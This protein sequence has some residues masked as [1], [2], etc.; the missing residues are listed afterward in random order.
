MLQPLLLFLVIGANAIEVEKIQKTFY[1]PYSET[2]DVDFTIDSG[3][4]IGCYR[5]TTDND[6]SIEMIPIYKDYDHQCG[7]ILDLKILPGTANSKGET[8]IKITATDIRSDPESENGKLDYVVVVAPVARVSMESVKTKF[9]ASDAAAPFGLSAYDANDNEMDTLDGLTVAWFIGSAKDVAYF[10]TRAPGGPMAML[11]PVRSGSGYVIGFIEDEFYASLDKSYE[12]F[13]ITAPLELAP[14]G[15]YMLP[16]A[17]TNVTLFQIIGS[18]EH[19]VWEAIDIL[20]PEPEF[21]LSVKDESIVKLDKERGVI[22][23]L[24]AGEETTIKVHGADGK[25]VKGVP[26]RVSDPYR[27]EI[28]ENNH[29]ESKQLYVNREYN[30]TVRIYDED[31]HLLHPSTNILTKTTF[32]KQFDVLQVSENGLSARVKTLGKG[33]GKMKASLRSTLD[34][35]DEETEIIPHLKGVKEFELYEEVVISPKH[36]FLPWDDLNAENSDYKLNYKTTGGNGVYQYLVDRDDLATTSGEGEKGK[37]TIDSGPGEILVT[38]AME[39]SL[40]NND[41]AKIY[42][43]EVASIGF[44][45]GSSESMVNMETRLPVTAHG[46]HPATGDNVLFDDCNDLAFDVKL[47]NIN[48]FEYRGK[49]ARGDPQESGSCGQLRIVGNKAGASTLVTISFM[50]SNGTSIKAVKL[51]SV[52]R[53]LEPIEPVRRNDGKV[54]VVLA[55]GT[56]RNIIWGGGPVPW[57]GK[58]SSYYKKVGSNDEAVMSVVLVPETWSREY[59][60][61]RVTCLSTGSTTGYLKL[62]N[63]PSSTNS[64]PMHQQ[65]VFDVVCSEPARISQVRALVPM[66]GGSEYGSGVVDSRTGRVNLYAYRDIRVTWI[67]KNSAGQTLENVTSLNFQ[68]KM[69][70][71]SLL[72]CGSSCVGQ[73]RGQPSKQLDTVLL[74]A[75]PFEMLHPQ[76]LEGDVDVQIAILGYSP[77]VLASVGAP[78]PR[79]LS[80]PPTPDWDMEDYDEEEEEGG[81]SRG[82]AETLELTLANDA[83]VEAVADKFKKS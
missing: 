48:D 14:D 18:K 67:V 40:H 19:P 4:R 77:E 6:E 65:R 50:L 15:A 55:I 72:A 37:V 54:G 8:R 26:I 57:V 31:N 81:A 47:S 58:P 61:V 7:H 68:F 51:I 39:K 21:S 20:G 2:E 66:Q 23:A 53:N 49:T 29:P 75:N 73:H 46:L 35:D 25:V 82:V 17:E 56:T 70:D 1:L 38:V 52:Y 16:G 62:G 71:D 43:V 80:P 36:T 78:T 10:E 42:L 76:S 28:V 32:G 12:E 33:I 30:L 5:W 83:T 22:T 45:N 3:D 41:T 27:V 59:S 13:S 64:I 11:K 44:K 74:P 9:K 69:S 34:K 24:K 79:A 63:N 60:V